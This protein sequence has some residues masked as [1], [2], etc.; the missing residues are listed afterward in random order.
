MK[1][2]VKT[3][4]VWGIWSQQL[5]QSTIKSQK[6]WQSSES[7]LVQ[8]SILFS[9][10][11]KQQQKL[12]NYVLLSFWQF[13]SLQEFNLP[14]KKIISLVIKWRRQKNRNRKTEDGNTKNI[15]IS[16]RRKYS[17]ERNIFEHE[18]YSRLSFFFCYL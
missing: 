7:I 1:S 10:K 3:R 13:P 17:S 15:Y 8:F 11:K 14:C 18:S 9:S 5:S 2:R 4:Q 6:G 12:S 16:E